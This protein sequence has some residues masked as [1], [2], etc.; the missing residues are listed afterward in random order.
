MYVRFTKQH[1]SQPQRPGKLESAVR[2]NATQITVAWTDRMESGDVEIT[3]A[4]YLEAVTAAKEANGPR[5]NRTK[6]VF[7]R[8][9]ATQEELN[10]EI[11]RR[12]GIED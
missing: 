10:A 11:S 12:L 2:D 8:L 6:P 1:D 4:E 9:E 7:H 5:V 3:E